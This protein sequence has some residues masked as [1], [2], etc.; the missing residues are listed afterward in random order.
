M[1]QADGLKPFNIRELEG[2]ARMAAGCGGEGDMRRGENGEGE[3]RA[4]EGKAQTMR[5]GCV[6]L[7]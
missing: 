6:R 2:L 1:E 3:R 4:S 5:V 7:G